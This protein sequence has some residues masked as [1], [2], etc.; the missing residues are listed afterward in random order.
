MIED[1]LKRLIGFE[2]QLGPFA[3]AQLRLLAE[4][5][6]LGASTSSE[7]RMYV[8]DTLGNPYIEDEKLGSIYEP[9]AES[10]KRANEIKKNQPVLVVIGNPPYKEKAKGR[11]GWIERGSPEANVRAPLAEWFPPTDWDVGA[12]VKHLRNLYVYYWRWATWKAFDHHPDDD[13][14]IVCFITVAGFLN[15]PGFQKMRDYLRRK[16]DE[17]W[18]IDCSP[19]GHQPEVSTRV[20]E[21]VQQPVCI[22]LASRSQ[23]TDEDAPAVVRFR[24][25]PLGHRT[26]KFAA[27]AAIDIDDTGWIE[28]P[29][30]WRDPFLPASLGAWPTYPALAD[31]FV[32][33]GSGVMP[34]RTWVIAPDRG[35]LVDRWDELVGAPEAE[36]EDLFHP[37]Q[38]GDRSTQKVVTAGLAGYP[39]NPKPV[40]EE[41][42]PG[43]PPVRYA[44]RSF[45]RQWIIPRQPADQ[46]AQ[47]RAL[48]RIL[49][50]AGASHRVA[51][52]VAQGRSCRDGFRSCSRPGSPQGQL[53]RPRLPTLARRGRVSG[54]REARGAQ[55]PVRII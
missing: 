28:C 14:G 15:G 16:A 25:L 53:R 40:G 23:A 21:A 41:T 9:I 19:D 43:L 33:D 31:L 49:E 55:D 42:G 46:S 13:K 54:E 1:A 34:G 32:Y 44:F 26:D 52:H 7:L 37:H 18:V 45:D 48:G 47:P 2:I 17:L 3:V 11:G 5:A 12:H 29:T 22:V 39:A 35:S 30:G 8:T 51:P 50:R 4:L 24:S 20:F 38:T 10:R 36:K 6:D 27:L